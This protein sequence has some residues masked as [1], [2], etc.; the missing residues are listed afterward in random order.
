ME[1]PEQYL[2]FKNRNNLFVQMTDQYLASLIMFPI[3][4]PSWPVFIALNEQIA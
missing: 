3:H 4:S 1:A 2:S